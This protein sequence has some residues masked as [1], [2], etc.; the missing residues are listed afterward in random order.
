MFSINKLLYTSCEAQFSKEPLD[1]DTLPD[2]SPYLAP[3]HAV[4]LSTDPAVVRNLVT[5]TLNAYQLPFTQDS[6][7]RVREYL[8]VRRRTEF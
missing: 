6:P 3:T 8:R 1:L 5:M 4:A 7:C 2:V